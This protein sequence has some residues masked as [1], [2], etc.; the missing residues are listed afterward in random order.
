MSD[1]GQ[2]EQEIYDSVRS[3]SRALLA[4]AILHAGPEGKVT[5]GKG[6]LV[7]WRHFPSGEELLSGESAFDVAILLVTLVGPQATAAAVEAW[8]QS[9]NGGLRAVVEDKN[10]HGGG[11]KENPD[12]RA[13]PRAAGA[14]ERDGWH[15]ISAQDFEDEH[16][17]TD[18]LWDDL[19]ADLRDSDP[20]TE[21]RQA[22]IDELYQFFQENYTEIPEGLGEAT[23]LILLEQDDHMIGTYLSV[24]YGVRPGTTPRQR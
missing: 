19:V 3:A 6:R 16:G 1:D 10:I 8:E 7:D 12:Y 11:R 18:R 24:W 23:G 14:L 4:G 13:G 15:E 21:Q 2:E 20:T 17:Q 5:A 22:W 9:R